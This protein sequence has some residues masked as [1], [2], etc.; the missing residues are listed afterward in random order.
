MWC[1]ERL[2]VTNIGRWR[3]A[4][5]SLAFNW[6]A[7][8]LIFLQTVSPHIL[9]V[10]LLYRAMCQRWTGP[11]SLSVVLPTFQCPSHLF[12]IIIIIHMCVNISLSHAPSEGPC[13]LDPCYKIPLGFPFPRAVDHQF[14]FSLSFFCVF[15]SITKYCIVRAF[16]LVRTPFAGLASHR[17]ICFFLSSL[18]RTGM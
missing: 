14:S 1:S 4:D 13:S 3:W 12:Y 18:A 15:N 11:L 9:C 16:P 2:P 6:F 8:W 7:S 17:S 10:L 5:R